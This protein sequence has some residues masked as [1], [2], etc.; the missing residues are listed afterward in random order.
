MFIFQCL[1]VSSIVLYTSYK[2]YE[3]EG[4][5]RSMFFW[6]R[7]FPIYLHYRL[8]EWQVR[9][10]PEAEQDKRFNALHDMYAP[11]A[12]DIILDIII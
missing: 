10:L 4:L 3:N 12:M 2:V 1:F 11:I 6:R 5:K 7:A 9:N 8:V